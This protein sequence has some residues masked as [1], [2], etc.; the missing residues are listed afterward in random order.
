MFTC[1][2]TLGALIDGVM[3]DMGLYVEIPR[4]TY[5]EVVNEAIGRL[6]TE[7]VCERGE[8]PFTPYN[9]SISIESIAVPA[10]TAPLREEDILL[11]RKSAQFI[12]RLS[13]HRFLLI[14]SNDG[15]FYTV[16][17]GVLRFTPTWNGHSLHLIYRRRPRPFTE[18]DE[19]RTIPLPEEYLSLLRAK[20]RGEIYK[21]ANEDVLSAKWL[22][23]YNS[24]LP[25]FAAYCRTCGGEKA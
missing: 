17:D 16:E 1:N 18:T 20:L 10:D 22:G 11:I 4:E 7:V 24:I 25:A 9:G 8:V 13:P 12:H 21:L 23:E 3:A 5:R 6:Y 14:T 2:Q 15:N 19:G